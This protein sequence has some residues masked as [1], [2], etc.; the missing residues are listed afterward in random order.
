MKSG[1]A[2]G[3][4]RGSKRLVER[5]A[6][7]QITAME[8]LLEASGVHAGADFYGLIERFDAPIWWTAHGNRLFTTPEM[9]IAALQQHPGV[10]AP[11]GAIVRIYGDDPR[12][13]VLMLWGVG[14]TVM[15]GPE[16]SLPGA[17]LA[18]GTG[19]AITIDGDLSA[20]EGATLNARNGGTIHVGRGGLWSSDVRLLTD[21]M[22]AIRDRETGERVNLRGGS[23]RVDEQVWLGQGSLLLPGATIGRETVIGARSVVTGSLPAY[24]VCAGVPAR[25]LRTGTTWTHED[26]D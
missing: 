14:S 26:A 6:T 22:H 4:R 21:D 8:N 18:C 3:T 25:V 23:V 2:S 19:G 7:H 12:L 13:A 24:A 11:S 10:A 9:S 5:H 1:T 17:T 15:I 20:A 16:T